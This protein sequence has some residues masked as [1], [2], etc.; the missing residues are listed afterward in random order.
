[1][2]D[3]LI[4][5]WYTQQKMPQTCCDLSTNL[6]FMHPVE[7]CHYRYNETVLMFSYLE[8]PVRTLQAQFGVV[9]DQ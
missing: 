4:R 9:R 7:R 1:M 5:E 6:F 3:F 2:P 8:A